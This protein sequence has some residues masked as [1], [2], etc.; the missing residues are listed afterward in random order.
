VNL[1]RARTV[2]VPNVGG[3]AG[4]TYSFPNVKVSAGYRG[5]F[6]FGAMDTG[7][8]TAKKSTIGFYGPFASIGIGIGG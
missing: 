2:A 4:V 3:F 8:D 5:D 7:F 6:F 1:Q